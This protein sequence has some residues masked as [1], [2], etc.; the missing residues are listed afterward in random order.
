MNMAQN[1]GPKLIVECFDPESR[2]HMSAP[3]IESR[4]SFRMPRIAMEYT[5]G[6]QVTH[7]V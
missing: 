7:K 3:E 4:E 2:L 5:Q 1:A 6:L